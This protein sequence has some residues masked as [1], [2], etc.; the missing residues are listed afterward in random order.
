MNSN[1]ASHSNLVLSYAMKGEMSRLFELKDAIATIVKFTT[2]KENR[3]DGLI[4]H[5]RCKI[6]TGRQEGFNNKIKVSKMVSYG[7]RDEECFF[8]LIRYLSLP[9][10]THLREKT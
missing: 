4:A 6:S 5:A 8:S 2:L 1:L 7:Y 3:L 9:L 10:G